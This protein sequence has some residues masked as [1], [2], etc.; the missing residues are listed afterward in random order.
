MFELMN[1]TLDLEKYVVS[2]SRI[3]EN[4]FDEGAPCSTLYEEVFH[5]K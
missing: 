5:T 4:E 1:G 2:E 3:V